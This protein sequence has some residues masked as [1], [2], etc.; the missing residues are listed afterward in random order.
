MVPVATLVELL[1]D[2]AE[3]ANKGFEL[4]WN[5]KSG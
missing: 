4:V 3:L 2:P 1:D 5:D